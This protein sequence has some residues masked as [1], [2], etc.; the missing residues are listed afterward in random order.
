MIPLKKIMPSPTP[1][2]LRK[3]SKETP[4][5]GGRTAPPPGVAS[6]VQ[7]SLVGSDDT[8][9]RTAE[10]EVAALAGIAA[11][12]RGMS[13]KVEVGDNAGSS[14]E[15]AGEESATADGQVEATAAD[16]LLALVEGDK[17]RVLSGGV[18]REASARAR[19]RARQLDF[20]HA[21]VWEPSGKQAGREHGPGESSIRYNGFKRSA[22]A[23]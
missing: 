3:R 22:S 14:G 19:K 12:R 17:G 4:P 1:S 5:S 7:A 18:G 8:S 15:E 2:M 10:A 21:S 13:I 20:T 11:L 16:A 6:S 9:P 23:R